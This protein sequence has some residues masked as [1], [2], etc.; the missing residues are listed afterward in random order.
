[1]RTKVTDALKKT[2]AELSSCKA[3]LVEAQTE[4]SQAQ[5]ERRACEQTTLQRE[6]ELKVEA[7][8]S[9]DSVRFRLGA[10]LKQIELR[11]EESYREREREEN[12]TREAKEL[13]DTAERQAQ[14]MQARLDES[15]ARLAAFSRCMSSLQDDRDRVLDETRQ[16]ESRFNST[17]QGKEAEV[18]EGETRSRDLA[19]Q[20]QKETARR[21]ELQLTVDR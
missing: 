1:M 21:E 18:R 17:L 7:E 11:L 15:L 10:E 8:Q 2:E 13:A 14:Q 20:L 16:W 6:A 19:E 5:A 3:Q 9:L 12:A 4:A